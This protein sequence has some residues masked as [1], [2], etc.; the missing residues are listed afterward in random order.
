MALNILTW[1]DYLFSCSDSRGN[2]SPSCL[3]QTAKLNSIDPEA[4]LRDV[5]S[6]IA[7]RPINPAELLP[8]N[9]RS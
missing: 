2:A 7:D 1:T 6:R 5:L 9:R 3:I 4:Y 8:W